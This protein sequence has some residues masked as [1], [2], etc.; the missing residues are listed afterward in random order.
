LVVLMTASIFLRTFRTDRFWADYCLRSLEKFASD[1][2][3]TI[4]CIPRHD[5]KHFE[6]TDFHGAQ[7][8]WV[9][10][11]DNNG[12]RRQ[13]VCKLHA[14]EHCE[15]DLIFYIDSDC[16][17]KHPIE[18]NDFLSSR[19]P[20]ALIRH[21]VDAETALPWKA[22]TEK[23]L[24]FEPIFEGMAALPQIIDRRVLPMIRAH[25]EHT[26]GM[27]LA[28][29]VM[30]QPG[31]DFSEFNAHSAFAHRFTPYLYDWRIANPGADGFPRCL[32]QRWSYSKEGIAK[33]AAQYEEILAQP[34][35][36]R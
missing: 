20:I 6:N 32:F 10:E 12:Y 13:Q 3:E 16:F 8:V 29:Y 19:R 17:V 22:I 1:F 28:E 2:L 7:V 30:A 14:D 24:G 15:G 25:A 11:P 5:A 18:P 31:N 33:Y 4:V 26:H 34:A 36:V 21:W 23:F 35:T 9:D 27:T